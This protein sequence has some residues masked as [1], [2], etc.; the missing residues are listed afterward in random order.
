MVNEDVLKLEIS[1]SNSLSVEITNGHC[2]LGC[3]EFDNIFREPLLALE[4]LVQLSSLDEGHHEVE[5]KLR[6]EEVV[7]A[8][9][10]GVVA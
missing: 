3:V 10:E 1:V 8:N 5:T 4:D 2:N 6:L 7:H 9:E